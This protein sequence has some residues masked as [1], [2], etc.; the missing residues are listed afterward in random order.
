L[1]AGKLSSSLAL[2]MAF[3]ERQGLAAWLVADWNRFS[4]T[5]E[6]EVA[7][8]PSRQPPQDLVL[9]LVELVIGDREAS[10]HG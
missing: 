3:I 6:N 10:A 2:E 4:A 1:E 5:G 7:E 9:A 8:F